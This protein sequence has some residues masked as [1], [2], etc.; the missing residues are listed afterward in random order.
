[1][2]YTHD[3]LNEN[4]ECFEHLGKKLVNVSEENYFFNLKNMNS[5]LKIKSYPENSKLFRKNEKMKSFRF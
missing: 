5:K 3:E 2:F 4:G 1:M